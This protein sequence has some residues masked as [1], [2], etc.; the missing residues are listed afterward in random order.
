MIASIDRDKPGVGAEV[1]FER[2]VFEIVEI[3]VYIGF[4]FDIVI[5]RLRIIK[6]N[7]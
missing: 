5:K 7:I 6:R 2:Y 3:F 1:M 4:C